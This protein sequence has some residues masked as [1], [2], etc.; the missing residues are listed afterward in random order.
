MFLRREAR[1]GVGF[2]GKDWLGEMLASR[3][4]E[5]RAQLIPI[6]TPELS[7]LSRRRAILSDLHKQ[8]QNKAIRSAKRIKYTEYR[9]KLTISAGGA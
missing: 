8:A 5:K 1:P 7:R 2:R 9:M 4:R 3:G 6:A